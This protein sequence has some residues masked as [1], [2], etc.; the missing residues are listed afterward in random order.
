MSEE[1][2]SSGMARWDPLGALWRLLAAPQTLM[3]LLGVLALLLAGGALI[4]QMFPRA[5]GEPQPWLLEQ[6]GAWGG[7]RGFAQALGL[8]ASYRAAWFQALL[9]LIG[10]CLFVRLIESVEVAWH[11]LGPGRWSTSSFAFWGGAAPQARI[12]VAGFPGDARDEMRRLLLSEGYSWFDVA[13]PASS[14]AVIGRRLWGLWARVAVYGGLIAALV[15]LA[16]LGD[17]GWQ[18]EAW[19]PSP[20]T[21]Q[22]LGHGGPFSVRLD[23]FDLWQSQAGQLRGAE[24]Q[25]TWLVEGAAIQQATVSAGRPS[26]WR[27]MTVR[28]TAYVPV[29][30]M[31]AW[32]DEDRLLT[33][34]AAGNELLMPG[35]IEVVFATP[36][37]RPLV[38]IP[39]QDRFLVLAYEPHCADRRASLGVSLVRNGESDGRA[40]GT[41]HESGALTAE[42][43]RL[44]VDLA[45]RPVLRVDYRPGMGLILAG[46]ALA[47]LGL[48]VIWIMPF[49]LAWVAVEEGE[50]QTTAV[51]LLAPAGA[52]GRRWLLHLADHL[53]DRLGEVLARGD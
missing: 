28:Q 31:R 40:L 15:G 44:Q 39:G 52:Q 46:A 19:Q 37:D 23:A 25:V 20:G 2:R 11:A 41:L 47:L 9:G 14:N 33:L 51:R 48:A 42:G 12:V 5:E 26:S 49:R 35:E 38:L 24:S 7:W 13:G 17:W 16:I 10:L 36:E 29:V 30:R 50:G 4:S 8:F 53:R 22:E 32:D 34:Q 1:N 27:G 3:V 18:S 21:S 43:L 45:Y 6:G